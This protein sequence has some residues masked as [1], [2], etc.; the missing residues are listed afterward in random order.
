VYRVDGERIAPNTYYFK[1][2]IY[3]WAARFLISTGPEIAIG[4]PQAVR[5]I[6]SENTARPDR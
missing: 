1:L 4:S 5:E 2:Q 6:I 3:A